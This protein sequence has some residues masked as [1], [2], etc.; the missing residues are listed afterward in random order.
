MFL[1]HQS[2]S[3]WS[4]SAQVS[5]VWESREHADPH[6]YQLRKLAE[7]VDMNS[8]YF[9]DYMSLYQYKRN[10]ASQEKSFRRAMGNMHVLYAHEH[11]STLRI[12]TLTPSEEMHMDATV[13]VYHAPSHEVKPVRVADLVANRTAYRDRGWCIAELCWSS[14][15]SMGALSKEI[16]ET[17][18]GTVDMTGQAPMPPDVFIPR[19]KE[20]LQFTHRS[21]MDAVLKLQGKVSC[22]SKNIDVSKYLY[23]R[24]SAAGSAHRGHKVARI[25]SKGGGRMWEYRYENG[26]N[27]FI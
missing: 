2:I 5:H 23:S 9:Y 11:T 15:R 8:W 10:M 16:D 22:L 13:L 24:R 27:N 6:G 7:A 19:F 17:G 25:C 20:K 26:N 18:S 3:C 1:S 14:T 4:T 21:D 12:E